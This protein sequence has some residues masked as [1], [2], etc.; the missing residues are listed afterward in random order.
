MGLLFGVVRGL[1][2]APTLRALAHCGLHLSP[3]GF[4]CGLSL[5][6]PAHSC[7]PM[8]E[9]EGCSPCVLKRSNFYL[10]WLPYVML[11]NGLPPYQLW[12]SLLACA[13]ETRRKVSAGFQLF[14]VHMCTTHS[15]YIWF[16]RSS[17]SIMASMAA[18]SSEIMITRWS[19][20]SNRSYLHGVFSKAPGYLQNNSGAVLTTNF[21]FCFLKCTK[22]WFPTPSTMMKPCNIEMYV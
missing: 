2:H 21:L 16:S 18:L 20:T 17:R 15:E 14:W 3:S 7:V 10:S 11:M 5:C 13:V 9:Q 8:A 12:A 1:P 19:M 4:C 6:S 22:C